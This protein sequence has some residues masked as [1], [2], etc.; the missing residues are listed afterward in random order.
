MTA[1]EPV[2]KWC[3]VNIQRD[4]DIDPRKAGDILNLLFENVIHLRDTASA[5]TR[6]NIAGQIMQTV[7]DKLGREIKYRVSYQN[8]RFLISDGEYE[9]GS[10]NLVEFS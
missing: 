7:N 8:G 3:L 5:D 6:D 10:A 2:G 9:I 1:A 4:M